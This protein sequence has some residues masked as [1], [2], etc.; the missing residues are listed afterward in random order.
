MAKLTIVQAVNA[1]LH[2]EMA[3]DERVVV[4]GEDVAE[5]GGVFRATEGLLEEFGPDRVIDTPVA[6]SAIVGTAIGMALY[7][8]RPVPEIQFL[9]FIPPAFDQ[10][11]SHLARFRYRTGGEWTTPLVIRVPCGAG[12]RAFEHHS[13][14]SEAW[15]FHTPGL[16]VVMPA[17]PHDTKGLLISAIRD[18]DPVIFLEHKKIYRAIKEEVPEEDYTVP[19]GKAEIVTPGADVSVFAYGAMRY[20][21]LEAARQAEALDIDAEV[22][23]LRTLTPL[24]VDTIVA[25]VQRTGRAMIIH[26]APRTGG[27]GAEITSIINERAF[28]YLEAPIARVTG[29]DTPVPPYRL[30]DTYLPD[31]ERVLNAIEAT[32]NF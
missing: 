18:P 32:V 12:V 30:E 22:I 31:T 1:A 15:F 20:V 2:E 25:S 19:I 13:E 24:D 6:E 21:A 7:G 23:D 4:L 29:Y 9:G 26:E 14:S 27:V 11:V 8:L 3:Q 10:I 5:I 17:T 16:K 28:E